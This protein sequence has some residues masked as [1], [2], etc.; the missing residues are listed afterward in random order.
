MNN[1]NVSD[2]FMSGSTGPLH[3]AGALNKKTI[4]FYP[5]KKSSTSLRWETINS[6]NKRFSLTDLNKSR[7][8]I[9]IDMKKSL[10]EIQRFIGS[11]DII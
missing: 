6:F 11:Q 8:Y 1:I 5:N 9:T 10:L 3:V 7:K 2:V 4:A